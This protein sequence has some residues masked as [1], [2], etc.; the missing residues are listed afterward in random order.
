MS[1]CD[2][3]LEPF[4]C[5]VCSKEWT[6]NEGLELHEKEVH[7]DMSSRLEA[8]G[9]LTVATCGEPLEDL[10]ELIPERLQQQLQMANNLSTH[11]ILNQS[12]VS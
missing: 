1:T 5:D 2:E 12:K 8:L 4:L 7:E 10:G 11:S 3:P 9:Y 6:S